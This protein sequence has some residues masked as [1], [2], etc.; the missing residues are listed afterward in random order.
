MP[1]C[2]ATGSS[3]SRPHLSLALVSGSGPVPNDLS[4]DRVRLVTEPCDVRADDDVVLFYGQGMARELMRFRVAL[5]GVLPP[6]VV[7]AYSL[8]WGDV[9]LALE[10]G[11][12][13]YL[14]ENRYA[15]LLNEALLCASRGTGF[16]DPV[17]AAAWVRSVTGP[18]S[19]TWERPR[20]VTEVRPDR[21]SALSQRERQVMDLLASGMK[22]REVAQRMVLTE[23]S[24]RNY[25]SRIYHKLAVRGQSEAIL[26][27]IGRL[28]PSAPIA[29]RSATFVGGELKQP[30][31]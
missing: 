18:A 19:G 26:Y 25:L 7:L 1:P 9:S 23:K 16:L 11:A 21:R 20:A 17:V 2:V 15:F 14:L 13:G 5:G 29:R 28:E 24:V 6:T 8:D 22:V 3:S 10:Q 31:A 30:M 27:W 12:I 4:A